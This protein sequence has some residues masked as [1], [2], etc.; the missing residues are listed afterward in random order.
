MNEQEIP[1]IT[2]YHGGVEPDF[3]LSQ[4]DVLRSSQKQ[5]NS[6]SSYAGFYMYG[7]QNHDD[8]VKYAIQENNLKHTT[9]KGVVKITMPR[10]IKIY[11]VPPFTI[12]RITASQIQQLQQQG[13]DLIAGSMLGKMEYV[14]LNK[15]KIIN[16][17]FEPLENKIEDSYATLEQLEPLLSEP[18]YM[19]FGH[20]TGRMG[21]S[22]EVVDSIFKKG[23]RTKDNSLYFTSIGLSTPT[24][25]LKAQYKELGL[26]EPNI[27]DL[28]RQFNNWQHQ[29]SKKI[30]IARLPIEYINQMGD[31]SDRNGEMFGAF[32]NQEV[33]ENG[34][35]TYYLDS[36]FI[37]G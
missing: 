28:K 9:T 25:E 19:C 35:V 34:D 17:Q 20:G 7:E 27:E 6:N 12:T 32:Y 26:P 2:F 18:G 4:L 15:E 31:R 1:T 11:N 3:N 13:Y 16:M 8:A 29:D 10:D 21:N 30:I 14:L 5:Q 37:L 33:Q 36:K 23:L 24:P 22:N